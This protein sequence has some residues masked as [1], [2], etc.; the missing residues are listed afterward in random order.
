[1]SSPRRPVLALLTDERRKAL[2]AASIRLGLRLEYALN[3]T[4]AYPMTLDGHRAIGSLPYV[5][6]AP[7]WAEDPRDINRG[8][9]RIDAA[10]NAGKEYVA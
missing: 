5:P 2:I 1:M 3:G 7:R 4:P 8:L 9:A 10:L 6:G